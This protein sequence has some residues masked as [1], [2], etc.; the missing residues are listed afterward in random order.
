MNLECQ[1]K[2]TNEHLEREA[3]LYVRQSTLHQVME[4]TESTRRQYALRQQA[5]RL[6]WP[7]ERVA[8]IDE[9]QARSG[10]TAQGRGGFGRLVAE[11][12][13]G[14]AGL[15]LGLEVSRLAR[16]NA[17]WSRLLELCAL[18]HTLILDEDGLYDPSHPNDRL[19]LGI[20]GVLSEA[21]LFTLRARMLGG[22][23]AKARRGEL[24]KPLP[25][26]LAYDPCDRVVL[27]PDRQ[28]QQ[29]LRVFFDAFDRIG[30]ACGVVRYFREQN[31]LFPRRPRIGPSKGK[32]LWAPLAHNLALKV[33]RNPRYAGT[34]VHGRSRSHKTPEGKLVTR[35][36]PVDEWDTVL[37][38]AHPGYINWDQY[39]RNLRRL[40]QNAQACGADRRQSPPREG[41]ALLQG[42]VLCGI[43]GR[44]M[45]VRYRYR[46]RGLEPVYVCQ[47][48]ATEQMTSRCQSIAGADID[49]KISD[50]LLGLISP[51][52][53]EVALAVQQELESR[54]E[55]ADRLRQ[56]QVERA[57]HEAEL[58]R[59][60][61]LQVDP[62]NRLVADV[63]EADWND[64][65]RALQTAREQYEQQRQAD[66]LLFDEEKRRRIQS[67]TTDFP[68]LWRDP[69]TSAQQRKRMVRLLIEDV[70]LTRADQITMQL[71]FRGGTTETR[72]L[73]LPLRGRRT[74]QTDP[75]VV[76]LVDGWLDDYTCKQIAEQLNG[77]GFRSGKGARFTGMTITNICQS[78]GLKS[79]FDRLRE[80]GMRTLT[81]MVEH[82]GVSRR[83]V[84]QWR[85]NGLLRAVAYNDKPQYLYEP[86]DGPKPRKHQSRHCD[87]R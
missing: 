70:T 57:H 45:S 82:L 56:Q 33:L 59:Q 78:Y 74:C 25:I 53:L 83:T 24:K 3:Y 86:T 36:L 8:V 42:L 32:L 34:Y 18:T 11:V 87:D 72:T 67:L 85:R 51:M 5:V 69:A 39:H 55:E 37:P 77:Q 38:N 19:L 17:D 40:R 58:A 1:Q 6:G 68:S 23:Q 81:E 12:S 41:P 16:N 73:P 63:L 80:K 44:R 27:D 49:R 20:K 84:K 48:E 29:A 61:F 35:R 13:L 28:I 71:R 10:A 2:V 50:V 60:R 64:K 75:E 26:G 54:L 9:D 46:N 62:G 21:E 76:R 22:I 15:V 66:H 30:T 65:L 52:T 31:L 79:R 7:E 14:R 4:N 47:R 43:C